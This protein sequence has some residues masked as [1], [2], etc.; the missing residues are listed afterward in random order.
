MEKIQEALATITEADLKQVFES[1]SL[2]IYA[3]GKDKEPTK[4]NQE[5]Y[6]DYGTLTELS[7][8]NCQYQH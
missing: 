1:N 2:T 7:Y 5:K 8:Y 3:S 6:Q 4:F